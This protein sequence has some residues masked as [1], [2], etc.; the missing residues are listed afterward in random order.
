LK[1]QKDAEDESTRIAFGN[2]RSEVIDLWHQAIEKDKILLSLIEKLKKSQA[3]LATLSEADQKISRL[4][5][6]K[7]A[8]EKHIADLE[9]ALSAQVELHKSEVIRLE[10]KLDEVIE[11]FNV[12]QAK[13][14]IFDMERSR[15]QKNV[16]ELRQG[17]EECF[18]VAMQCSNK[19][20]STFAKVG[21][22]S[23]DQNFTR[24]DPEGVIK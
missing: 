18:S 23:T 7:K 13:H 6:E 3:D 15:V 2:M 10:K 11:N 17:K 19:L 21:A 8:D 20:K 9:Y 4:E 12:E 24:G 1:A 5:E 14:E 22:I 16:E